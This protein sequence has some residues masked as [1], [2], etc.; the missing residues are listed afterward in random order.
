VSLGHVG[1]VLCYKAGRLARN[2]ADWYPLLDLCTLRGTLIA[3]A[4]GVYDPSHYNDRLLL[5]LRGMMSEAELHLLRLRMQAGKMRQIEK[6][7]Y[8]QVL[9]TGLERLADERVVKHPDEH[10]R[11]AI[12]LV[13]ERFGSLGTVPKV[14]KSLREGEVLLPR[15]RYGGLHTGELLWV[16]PTNANIYSILCNPAYA[17]A[18]VYGRSAKARDGSAS[19]DRRVN[20]PIE[21]WVSVHQGLCILPT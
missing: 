2:N 9:P 12:E 17:G 1:I 7:T 11:S 16:R 19:P 18:F 20:K 14:L 15:F 13:L 3:D 21:E 4:D 10:V 5:G 8:R 6:G